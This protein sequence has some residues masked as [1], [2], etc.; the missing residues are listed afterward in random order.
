VNRPDM[1]FISPTLP[2]PVGHGRALRAYQFVRNWSRHYRIHLLVVGEKGDAARAAPLSGL[3]HRVAFRPYRRDLAYVR[4]RMLERFWPAGFH[5]RERVPAAWA[6]AEGEARHPEP[7]FPGVAFSVVHVFRLYTV[8]LARPFL[9]AP[10]LQ[11][12][13]DDIESLTNQRLAD[14]YSR[15]GRIDRAGRHRREAAFYEELERTWLPRFHRVFVCSE[16]DRVELAARPGSPRVE[17]V[18]NVV[19]VPDDVREPPV[20]APCRFLFVGNFHYYPNQDG[21]DWFTSAVLPC[22]RRSAVAPFR[23]QIV[24]GGLKPR[25]VRALGRHPEVEVCGYV[26]DLAGFYGSA[27]AVVAPIRAGGGTRIKIL[28]AFA[29][30]RPVVSTTLGAE[31][32]GAEAGVHYLRGDSPEA[33]A[34]QCAVLIADPDQRL[35]LAVAARELVA[36]EY[37]TG[38]LEERLRPRIASP[39]GMGREPMAI[40]AGVGGV[41]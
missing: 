31:G 1:L 33:F 22:L 2:A 15:N 39:D 21:I 40:V 11:L 9:D 7:V 14:L 36:R 4:R 34:A 37:S 28:E 3:V 5:R 35:R 19:A 41:V 38:C 23:V 30:G 32:I 6:F 13:L 10:A 16:R 8:P 17:V 12:D 26:P 29:H 25:H 20:D 27:H 24:G 18:P